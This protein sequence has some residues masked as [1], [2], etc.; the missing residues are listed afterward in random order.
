MWAFLTR[1]RGNTGFTRSPSTC[2]IACATGIAG[3]GGLKACD[4]P[5]H[6]LWGAEDPIAGRDVAR[7]HHDEI[8]GSTLTLLDGG[9]HY[10]ML[11][12]PDRWADALLGQA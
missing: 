9:G 3:C 11:E 2:A 10:P 8:A 1:D 12:A 4:L 7:V 6:V 5:T